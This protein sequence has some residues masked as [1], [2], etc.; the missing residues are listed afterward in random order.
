MSVEA[1]EFGWRTGT[2]G[3]RTASYSPAADDF[4]ARRPML[5]L[6]R[7]PCRSPFAASPGIY[8]WWFRIF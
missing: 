2:T 8:H 4:H 1:R 7:S 6:L 3:R 5:Q